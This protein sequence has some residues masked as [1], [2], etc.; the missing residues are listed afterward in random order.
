MRV[1]RQKLYDSASDYFDLDG[2]V[3]MKLSRAAAINVCRQAVARGLLIVMIEGGITRPN[4]TFEARSDAIWK[5]IDPPIDLDHAEQNNFRAA[6]FIRSRARDYNTFIITDAPL[7]GYRH[8]EVA[9]G[10]AEPEHR[11]KMPS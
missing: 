3:I 1:N 6:D 9:P 11:P 4:N 8:R 2:S 5:G 7:T 10:S